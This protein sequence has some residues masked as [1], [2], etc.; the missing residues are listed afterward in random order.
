MRL[1]GQAMIFIP[2][3][4][5]ADYPPSVLPPKKRLAPNCQGKVPL[6]RAQACERDQFIAGMYDLGLMQISLSLVLVLVLPD[7]S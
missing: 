2:S 1:M 3:D 5:H 4:Y 6:A 7:Q